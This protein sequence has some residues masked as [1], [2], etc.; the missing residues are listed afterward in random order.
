MLTGPQKSA[1][2]PAASLQC[3]LGRRLEDIRRRIEA[4][5]LRSGRDPAGIGLIAVSKTQPAQT[6]RALAEHGQR[7]FGENYLQEALPKLAAL[8]DL[9][10][11]WHYIGR[12]QSNKTREVAQWFQWVHTLDRERI[13]RRL[14]EQRPPWAPPLQVCIQVR[15]GDESGKGGVTPEA[16]APLA[17][18]IGELP[19]LRLR[20]LMC[21]PPPHETFEAQQAMFTILAEH[22]RRLIQQGFELDTLS[23]GMSADLEAAVAAGATWVRIGSALFGKRKRR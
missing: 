1:D 9:P 10:L 6:I 13:A 12:L 19:R 23:M 7:D 15:L 18:S 14:N 22:R 5:A 16:L 21:I 17:H 2:L 4:A 8:Q 20:G 11:T 3:E